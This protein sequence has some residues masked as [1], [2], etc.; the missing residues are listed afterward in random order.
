MSKGPEKTNSYSH[1]IRRRVIPRVAAVG[2]A[3]YFTTAC[4][5]SDPRAN[6]VPGYEGGV[7]SEENQGPT[8]TATTALRTSRAPLATVPERSSAPAQTTI[9]ETATQTPST[10]TETT[11]TVTV[12]PTPTAIAAPAS[13]S[14]PVS[15]PETE[16]RLSENAIVQIDYSGISQLTDR[17]ALG[18]RPYVLP[19]RNTP[20]ADGYVLNS[21]DGQVSGEAVWPEEST[22]AVTVVC[23]VL[24]ENNEKWAV[25]A[26]DPS[27]PHVDTSQSMYGYVPDDVL[28]D[29][30]PLNKCEPHE[31]PANEPLA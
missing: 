3:L 10:A 20:F 17:E 2:I 19:V 29:T 1:R 24:G 4:G 16:P 18:N 31:N 9:T 25:V 27:Y 21:A 22:H 6:C 30:G 23:K 5:D 8:A 26:L 15:Q 12:T 28:Q 11:E 7:C 14:S 13:S